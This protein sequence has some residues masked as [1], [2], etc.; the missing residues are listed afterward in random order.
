[1]SQVMSIKLLEIIEKF[2]PSWRKAIEEAIIFFTKPQKNKYEK[3]VK[4]TANTLHVP[5]LH[6]VF[7][8]RYWFVHSYI[9]KEL[10][11]TLPNIPNPDTNSEEIIRWIE[12]LKF[13]TSDK[14]SH[15]EWLKEVK[16]TYQLQP[17]VKLPLGWDNMRNQIKYLIKH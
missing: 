8:L 14:N 17:N 13:N 4:P 6:W 10:E 16:R 7:L 3:Y 15:S 11:V 9:K 2:P 12:S 5:P 1:M